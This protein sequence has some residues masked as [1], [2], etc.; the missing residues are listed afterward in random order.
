MSGFEKTG[1]LLAQLAAI[2]APMVRRMDSGGWTA[3][4]EFPAPE[5]VTANV[6]SD[7]KHNSPDEALQVCID[8]LGGLQDMLSVPSPQPRI[9][10]AIDA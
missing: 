7:F 10:R 6:R 5:G 4:V 9:L 2:G 1:Q 3:S 8:R